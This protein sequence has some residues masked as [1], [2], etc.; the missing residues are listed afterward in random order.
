[1]QK[2]IVNFSLNNTPKDVLKALVFRV[3]NIAKTAKIEEIK[4]FNS[5]EELKEYG[6]SGYDDNK[7]LAT[8][9]YV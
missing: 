4:I 2:K 1:M 9:Y 5:E 6:M 3:N 7:F 8:I